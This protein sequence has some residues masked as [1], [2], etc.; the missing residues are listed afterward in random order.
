MSTILP[1]NV[2]ACAKGKKSG[3]FGHSPL[4]PAAAQLGALGVAPFAHCSASIALWKTQDRRTPT[5]VLPAGSDDLLLLVSSDLNV[6][7]SNLT[8]K[9]A[10]CSFLCTLNGCLN[11]C[12]NAIYRCS[13]GLKVS[14]FEM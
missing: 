11:L 4:T 12:Y 1:N 14:M 7:N 5:Q 10:C 6:S 8:S 2:L 13:P 9:S 3:A